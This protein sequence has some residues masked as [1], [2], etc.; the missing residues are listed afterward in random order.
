M[1]LESYFLKELTILL[2]ESDLKI[3]KALKNKEIITKDDLIL[4]GDIFISSWRNFC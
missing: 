1:S 3:L 4:C 2:Q